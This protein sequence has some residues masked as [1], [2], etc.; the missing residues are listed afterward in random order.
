MFPAG[1]GLA[2]RPGAQGSTP[3]HQVDW[4]SHEALQW[5]QA[6]SGTRGAGS[7]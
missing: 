7:S 5:P 4:R 6:A 1:S 2:S 3:V